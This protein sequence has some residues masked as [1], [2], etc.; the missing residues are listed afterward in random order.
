VSV[1]SIPRRLDVPSVTRPRNAPARHRSTTSSRRRWRDR[2]ITFKVSVLA[3]V[4]V[5][6]LLGGSSYA[7]QRQVQLHQLQSTLLQDQ[8]RY[9]AQVAALTND[10]APAHVA[11][12]AGH[13]HLVV[14]ASVTQ[15]PSVSLNSALPLA[16][17][18]GPYTVISRT[19]R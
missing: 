1:I 18:V 2:S 4:T 6:I 17:L 11:I 16:H 8:A 14:P 12:Q 7:A 3:A 19:Y 13:L 5:V 15:I 10:A 9:A